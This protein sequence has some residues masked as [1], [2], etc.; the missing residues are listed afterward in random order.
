[1]QEFEVPRLCLLRHAKSSWHEVGL[2]DHE[3][4]LNDR[5]RRDRL[6]MAPMVS[7][8]IR[9]TA[10]LCSSSRRTLQ[11]LHALLPY[12]NGEVRL[13]I[14]D[15]LYL[16]PVQRLRGLICGAA[17]GQGSVLVIG[18]NPGLHELSLQIASN[19]DSAAYARL[20][21]NLPTSGAVFFSGSSASLSRLDP[22]SLNLESFVTA[23]APRREERP[24]R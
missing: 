3:R 16:A 6:V 19:K 10:V 1:M 22:A 7:E 17:R 2:S 4:P 18:H 14:T 24:P 5:G 13:V 12:V 23:R 15:D 8:R 20:R 9:P 21:P 11:T